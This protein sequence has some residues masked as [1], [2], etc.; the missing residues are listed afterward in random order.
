MPLVVAAITGAETRYGTGTVQMVADLVRERLAV[1]EQGQAALTGLDPAPDDPVAA[2]RLRSA[3]RD[4]LDADPA[5]AQRL[6]ALLEAPSPPPVPPMPPAPA[7]S[8]VIGNS[9]RLRGSNISLGPLTISTTRGGPGMLWALIAVALGIVA[10]AVYGGVQVIGVDDTPGSRTSDAASRQDTTGAEG[11]AGAP[12]S[13]AGGAGDVGGAGNPPTDARRRPVLK[14][15]AVV[16]SVL[17]GLDAVPGGWTQESAPK[18]LKASG[19]QC[20]SAPPDVLFCGAAE[21]EDPSTNNGVSFEVYPFS[22]VGA[23]KSAYQAAKQDHPP[24]IAL[25]ALGDDSHAYDRQ[26]S[27]SKG[28]RS[29]VR[30]GSVVVGVTYLIEA[31]DWTEAYGADHL[32]ILTR[33]LTERTQQACN[34]QQPTARATL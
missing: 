11:D 33:M 6:N 1:S 24:S 5:F 10:L 15:Q 31:V 17:P 2:E 16:M 4:A 29:M 19:S 22:S 8:V 26:G 25:P 12:S 20:P 7:G 30:V 27:S 23:A 9:N 32:E 28:V 34:G 18:V 3:L 13:S 21:Y 14:D